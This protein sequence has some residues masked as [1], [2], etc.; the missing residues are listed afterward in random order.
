MNHIVGETNQSFTASTDGNYAVMVTQNGCSDT[1]GCY[2]ITI[3]GIPENSLSDAIRFYPNP[4]TDNL[5]I[6]TTLQ[7]KSIDVSDIT[8]RLLI[9]NHI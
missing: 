6:Q 1:S 9:Y 5:Q 4:V 8:G 3:T 7:I 2:N